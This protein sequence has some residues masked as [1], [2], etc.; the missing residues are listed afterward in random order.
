MENGDGVPSGPAAAVT[1]T[2]TAPVEA[3]AVREQ[4]RLMPIANVTR[5]MRR[6]LPP[7]AKISED[8]KELVQDCVSEFISFVT[9]E[10]NE[11][12]HAEHRKTVT[13]EDVVWAMDNLGFDDYV[14]PLTSFLQR[15]RASDG[16]AA[17][18]TRGPGNGAQMQVQRAMYAP[19][20]PGQGYDVAMAPVLQATVV[21][22]SV[23]AYGAGIAAY[24]GCGDEES[25]SNGMPMPASGTGLSPVAELS[26]SNSVR[27]GNR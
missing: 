3:T 12:C 26:R 2:R 25:S 11:R 20:P 27:H 23:V 19:P 15:M 4:D 10:A 17:V 21:S 7:H 22:P 24:V 16:R 5:I 6:V 1:E 18:A 9:G 8:A 13:G 14:M